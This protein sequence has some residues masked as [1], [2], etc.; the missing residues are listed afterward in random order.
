[1]PAK[2][3]YERFC[4]FLDQHEVFMSKPYDGLGGR[5]V[6]KEYAKDITDRK[7]YFDNCVENRTCRR[8]W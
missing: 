7:A 6:Q 8:N 3:G 5:D 2:D 4:N 1:M